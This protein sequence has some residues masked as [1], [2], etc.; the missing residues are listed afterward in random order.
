MVCEELLTRCL[1]PDSQM[2]GLGC[3]NMT[4]VLVCLLQNGTW[5]QFCVRNTLNILCDCCLRTLFIG[6]MFT[7]ARTLTVST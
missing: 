6:K 1:A 4:V 5:A 3:D 2:G 7:P